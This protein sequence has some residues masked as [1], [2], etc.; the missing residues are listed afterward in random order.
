MQTALAGRNQRPVRRAGAIER[1]ERLRAVVP[2]RHDGVHVGPSRRHE[3]RDDAR[4]DERRIAPEE[5]RPGGV[6]RFEPTGERGQRPGARMVVVDYERRDVDGERRQR[7][8]R[9]GDEHDLGAPRAHLLDDAR[10]Q[11][12]AV[13]IEPR[14]RSTHARRA[15]A[16]QDDRREIVVSHGVDRATTLARLRATML[17]RPSFR[18]RRSSAPGGG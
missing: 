7:L 5:Q 10:E 17:C 18:N 4:V 3:V 1:D 13:E 2:D 8:T 9:R 14:L 16:D 6:H 15:T 11:R 12:L